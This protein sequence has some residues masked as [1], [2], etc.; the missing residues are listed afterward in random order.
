MTL[1]GLDGK[2]VYVRGDA[3]VMVSSGTTAPQADGDGGGS[4]GKP[5]LV[6]DLRTGR[7]AAVADTEQNR[8]RLRGYTE[9]RDHLDMIVEYN[10]AKV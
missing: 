3:V 4:V 1:E 5:C 10:S 6:I 7:Q 8:D 9:A 2:P